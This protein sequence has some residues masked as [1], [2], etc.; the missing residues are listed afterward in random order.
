MSQPAVSAAL[1]KL[2]L[3]LGDELFVRAKGAMVPTPRALQL[4][5]AL[6]SVLQLIRFDILAQAGFDPLTE[7]GTFTISTSDIGELEV[8]PRL[9][10]RL[11][12]VAPKAS[13]RTVIGDRNTMA[14]QMEA[15]IIDLAVGYFP[16]LKSAVFHQQV[17]FS[18]DWVCIVRRDHPTFANGISLD[19]YRAADH[20]AV[21]VGNSIHDFMDRTLERQSITRQV[22]LTIAHFVNLPYLVSK[23][24]LVATLPRLIAVQAA[25]LY[26]LA[27][28]DTPFQT[29]KMDIKQVWHRRFHGSPKLIWL[30][31]L[32]AEA[33]QNKAR[34]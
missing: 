18:E 27:I 32:V 29:P 16:A 4:Q 9:M 22:A 26:P 14:A 7:R 25:S 5:D 33:C 31:K 11:S 1:G 3:A 15:G 20:V 2:R 24:D 17:L 34:L 10:S 19:G 23:S 12:E 30:R 8:L 28:F 13:I 21:A 6:R